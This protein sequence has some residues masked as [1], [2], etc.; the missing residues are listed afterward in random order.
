MLRSQRLGRKDQETLAQGLSHII[1][2]TPLEEV[3]I[4]PELSSVKASIEVR[5]G[6]PVLLL[7]GCQAGL[8]LRQFLMGVRALQGD[9]LVERKINEV[10]AIPLLV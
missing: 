8:Q 10:T 6:D 5:G 1:E 3:G 2:R 7:K 4:I 9:N